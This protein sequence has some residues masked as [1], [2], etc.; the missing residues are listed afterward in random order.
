VPRLA[1]QVEYHLHFRFITFAKPARPPCK[2]LPS[3]SPT[4]SPTSKR[5]SAPAWQLTEFAPQ[6]SFFFNAHSDLLEEVAKVSRRAPPVGQDHARPF[7]R[8]GSAIAAPAFP[9][10]NRRL[11]AYRA[12]TGE[13][14]CACSHQALAAVLGGCQSLHTNSMDEALAL[15][16]EESALIAL[17]TQQIIA[18][19]TGVA[20]AIDPVAAP[21]QSKSSP[22]KSKGRRRIIWPRLTRWRHDQSD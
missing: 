15:P 7:S 6:L 9:R 17:R 1:S 21:T 3:L 16:T 14:Y 8:P 19:E 13:Q 4:A 18:N 11:F 22:I 20:N 10:T 5:L 2:K 12:A